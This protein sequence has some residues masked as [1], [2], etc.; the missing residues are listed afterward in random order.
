MHKASTTQNRNRLLAALSSSEYQ[1][2]LPHLESVHLPHGEVLYEMGGHV[3]YVYF[4]SNSL[5][6]LV[7]QMENGAT[8]EVGLVGNDGMSGITAL[9][10]DEIAPDR[11]IVQIADGAMRA[12]LAVIREEFRR[13][14]ELQDLLLRYTR[15]HLKQVA[16]TAACNATH[17]V[18]ERLARWLLMCQDRVESEDLK[19]TQEFIADMLGTRRATVSGAAS[20]LQTEGLIQYHRGRIRIVDRPALEEFACECYEAVKAEF[21]RLLGRTA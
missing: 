15:A 9:I 11:A 18:E 7:T 14:G 17:A 20:A 1:R 6:S 4:P 10:G 21:D 5:I 13:G 19:L 12:Q 2:L 3:K 8:I 16:Q